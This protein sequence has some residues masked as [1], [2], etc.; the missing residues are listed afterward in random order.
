MLGDARSRCEHYVCDECA[1]SAAKGTFPEQHEDQDFISMRPRYGAIRV[2]EGDEPAV[3]L[4]P[5]TD[6]LTGFIPLGDSVVGRYGKDE[7][8]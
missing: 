4:G 6:S 8:T 5:V 1:Y 2:G 7:Q 3:V